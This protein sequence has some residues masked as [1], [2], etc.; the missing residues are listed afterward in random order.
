M[1]WAEA[2]TAVA[3]LV[4]TG[5]GIAYN[6]QQADKNRKHQF[7]MSNT[8]H[9]R[10]VADLRQAGLNPILSAGGSGGT[11]G[12]GSPSSSPNI[13]NAVNSALQARHT[14]GQIDKLK[15]DAALTRTQDNLLKPKETVAQSLEK[16]LEKNVKPAF[17]NNAKSV[18]ENFM[19]TKGESLVPKLLDKAVNSA[20][21]I[22]KTY[23]NIKSKI[24]NIINQYAPQN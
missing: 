24:N 19:G 6:Y 14:L 21:K 4:D 3:E 23:K 10:Q 22:P 16:V 12:S 2:I 13:G 15:A 11:T 20:K 18:K 5:A 9:Q 7:A 17:D 8:A 1:G